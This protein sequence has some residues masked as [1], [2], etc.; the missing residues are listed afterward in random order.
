MSTNLGLMKTI[1]DH[2]DTHC[3]GLVFHPHHREVHPWYAAI[4]EG[5]IE[6]DWPREV[7]GYLKRGKW[8]TLDLL[9]VFDVERMVQW[10]W[11]WM[12]IVHVPK[13]DRFI[14][15]QGHWLQTSWWT[16]S[17]KRLGPVADRSGTFL[18][19]EKEYEEKTARYQ[20]RPSEGSP[21]PLTQPTV[22]R[23]LYSKNRAIM[24]NFYYITI[25]AWRANQEAQVLSHEGGGGVIFRVLG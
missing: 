24:E 8:V 15:F 22:Q 5:C 4:L 7:A 3:R 12:K 9:S 2:V 10:W 6:T 25:G 13:N 17:R 16:D 23:T 20:L 14:R 1:K 11:W 21:V 19:C 18:L